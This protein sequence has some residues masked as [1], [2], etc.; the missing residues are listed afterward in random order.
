MR[1]K[2]INQHRQTA[3]V[4]EGLEVRFVSREGHL[5][6]HPKKLDSPNHIYI[7]RDM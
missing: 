4:G 7:T 3:E 2:Q 5:G 1:R 6:N